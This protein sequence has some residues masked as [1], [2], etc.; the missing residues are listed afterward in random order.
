L[1]GFQRKALDI[2][3][4]SKVREAFDL[5]KEPKENHLVTEK[6]IRMVLRSTVPPLGA[7]G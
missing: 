1:T 4:S 6:T 3:T 7:A 5:D 2:V